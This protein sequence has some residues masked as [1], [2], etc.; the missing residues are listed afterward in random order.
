MFTQKWKDPLKTDQTGC[1][2]AY[3]HS[4]VPAFSS[5]ALAL[6]YHIM[7]LNILYCSSPLSCYITEKKKRYIEDIPQWG[8]TSVRVILQFYQRFKADST[9]ST[10]LI[11]CLVVDVIRRRVT[12][13]GTLQSPLLH[14]GHVENKGLVLAS[15]SQVPEHDSTRKKQ[16]AK[17]LTATESKTELGQLV[18]RRATANFYQEL[19]SSV[20]HCHGI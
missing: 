13:L 14:R 6:T 19:A 12:T 20:F 17:C 3:S 7:F 1:S 18:R 4:S 5:P 9:K 2:L 11:T 15:Y 8:N 16:T 10:P